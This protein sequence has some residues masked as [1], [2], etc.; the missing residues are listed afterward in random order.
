MNVPFVPTSGMLSLPQPYLPFLGDTKESSYA[1]TAFGL[2]DWAGASC[3]GEVVCGE[4]SVT[5]GLTPL[6][7]SETRSRGARS[8]V[9]GVAHEGCVI[10]ARWL[11]WHGTGHASP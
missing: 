7:P 1:K 11:A 6:T 3:V 4:G 5:A 8:L 9:I 2:R 10:G